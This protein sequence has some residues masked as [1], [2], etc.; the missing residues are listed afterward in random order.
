M[1][2]R[3]AP[4]A[5]RLQSLRPLLAAKATFVRGVGEL[6]A[7][8]LEEYESA[9]AEQ[10]AEMFSLVARVNTL[11]VSRYTSPPAWRAGYELLRTAV[12]F[13][14]DPAQRKSLQEWVL[15]AKNEVQDGELKELGC[16]A[17]ARPHAT[18][19]PSQQDRPPVY[20]A[21]L[22]Q[23]RLAENPRIAKCREAFTAHAT[24][25]GGT[26]RASSL[27]DVLRSM[28]EV[29][30]P[31][32]LQDIANQ[33][34]VDGSGTVDLPEFLAFCES[35]CCLTDSEGDIVAW[36]QMALCAR[37]NSGCGQLPLDD[38]IDT[39]CAA[40]QGCDGCNMALT[41]AEC[42]E[43]RDAVITDCSDLIREAELHDARSWSLARKVLTFLRATLVHAESQT[44][45]DCAASTN[46]SP[47]AL[48]DDMEIF[49]AIF[50]AMG[51]PTPRYVRSILYAEL[52]RR[53]ML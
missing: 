42:D 23:E 50:V 53:L 3:A 41:D 47:V 36:L 26:I 7:V 22:D 30:S 51:S 15:L 18:H 52:P 33:L 48:I 44:S 32:E 37:D 34:D 19:C 43:L 20:P 24:N 12:R 49:R 31:P 2:A 16:G 46:E 1:E 35:R 8:V 9:E 28:G 25:G 13:M 39:I 4:L 5:S 10:Q 11:L 17:A 45:S 6:R 21:A 29:L 40:M 38:A 14:Q 27:E